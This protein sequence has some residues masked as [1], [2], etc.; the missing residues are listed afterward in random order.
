MK[1]E[2]NNY[3]DEQIIHIFLEKGDNAA[4]GILYQRYSNL[5]YGLMLKYVKDVE[6]SADLMME[7]FEK[8]PELLKKHQVQNFKSWWYITSKN[9]VLM[10][11]RKSKSDQEKFKLYAENELFIMEITLSGHHENEKLISEMMDAMNQLSPE[12]KTCLELFYF[13]NMSYK[14]IEKATGWTFNEIKSHIQ[15]GKRNLKIRL[16]TKDG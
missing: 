8:L 5:T 6:K 12:Q 10:H 1:K 14:E 11:L 16:T 3:T 4:I 7:L 13:K 15:N 2:Y 9:H